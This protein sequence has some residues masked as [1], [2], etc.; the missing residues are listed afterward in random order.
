MRLEPDATSK[1]FS[2]GTPETLPLTPSGKTY[3]YNAG[4]GV[5]TW[6]SECMYSIGTL[7]EL[8]AELSSPVCVCV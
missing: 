8:R 6:T 3:Y 5:T 1:V 2:K 7:A 4:T